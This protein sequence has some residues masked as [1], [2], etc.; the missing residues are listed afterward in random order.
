MTRVVESI[1]KPQPTDL[2]L[3]YGNP[4]DGTILRVML[5]P[6][7][8]E[9]DQGIAELIRTGSSNLGVEVNLF[10]QKTEE[11]PRINLEFPGLTREVLELFLGRF[12]VTSD[13]VETYFVRNRFT[14]NTLTARTTG[15]DGFGIVADA[16]LGS[17]N[18]PS[19]ASVFDATVNGSVPLTQVAFTGFTPTVDPLVPATRR[20]FAVGANGAVLF[21]EDTFGLEKSVRIPVT[22]DAVQVLSETEINQVGMVLGFLDANNKVMRL[23]ATG[24]FVLDGKSV[25][26]TDE[27]V[28]LEFEIQ[29][30]GSSCLPFDLVYTGLTIKC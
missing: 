25:N 23:E 28:S 2:A 7:N 19:Y 8:I 10:R 21:S 16:G 14:S 12:F 18:N 24:K 11:K 26:F 4:T 20:R 9:L 17:A 13:D 22:L 6:K 15:Q 3:T 1:L 30:D 27:T 29:F 5:P